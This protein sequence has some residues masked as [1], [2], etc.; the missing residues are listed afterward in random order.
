MADFVKD[1]S[2]TAA[3]G[4][5]FNGFA[6]AFQDAQDRK[7]K[8]Q[9]TQAKITA[10]QAQQQRDATDQ[11]IKMKSAGLQQSTPGGELTEAP[12][13]PQAQGK[14]KLDVFKS[15]GKG[16]YDDNGNLTDVS[17]DPDSMNYMKIQ[18]QCFV[19]ILLVNVIFL[20]VLK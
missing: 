9:E 19:Q 4:A 8:N 14:Q 11:A 3:A 6:Q 5:A 13:G 7:V 18:N 12:L 20:P 2:D 16:Q 17:V 1:Y 15:G 10:M